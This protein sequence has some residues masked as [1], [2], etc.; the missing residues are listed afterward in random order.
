MTGTGFQSRA[1]IAGDGACKVNSQGLTLVPP[2]SDHSKVDAD[3]YGD[4]Q[5]LQLTD[6]LIGACRSFLG[7]STQPIHMNVAHPVKHPIEA[8]MRGLQGYSN[9]RWY[10]SFWMSQCKIGDQQWEFSTLEK[11]VVQSAQ[12]AELWP[13]IG[14]KD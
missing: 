6:I 3:E 11:R 5:L 9:S 13:D 10:P 12:Q 14:V 8:Y 4:C 1:A 2:S 7:F